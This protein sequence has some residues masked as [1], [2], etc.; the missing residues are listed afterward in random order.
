MTDKYIIFK[1]GEIQGYT[2]D[3]QSAKRSIS[4]LANILIDELK[5][6]SQK[7]IRIFRENIDC[8]VKIYTQTQGQYI[9]GSVILQHTLICKSIPEY[10]ISKT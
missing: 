2:S 1:N 3:E 8:G 10:K 5:E 9:N 7:D 6:I 4:D